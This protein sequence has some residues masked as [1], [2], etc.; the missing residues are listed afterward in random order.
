MRAG[1]LVVTSGSWTP[2]IVEETAD[3]LEAERQVIGRFQPDEPELFGP[4]QFPVSAVTTENGQYSAFPIHGSPG[5]KIARVHHRRETVDPEELGD[6]DGMDRSI[7]QWF[8][9]RFLAGGTG[10]AMRMET[11]LYTNTPDE[12]FILDTHP[13]FPQV[14]VAAGFSGHGY[15][16]CPVVGEMLADLVLDG[17]T[18]LPRKPFRMDR[19]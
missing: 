3:V 11:C 14:S 19:F 7:L 13:S 6:I 2:K 12:R 9:D 17:E 1:S 4:E 10:P 8:G 18:N 5:V 16:F 15:K